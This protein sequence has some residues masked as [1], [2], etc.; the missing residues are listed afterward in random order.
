TSHIRAKTVAC[1]VSEFDGIPFVG[2]DSTDIATGAVRAELKL[3]GSA[4]VGNANQLA[5]TAIIRTVGAKYLSGSGDTRV[6]V[7][8]SVVLGVVN[9]M[10]VAHIGAA[11]ALQRTDA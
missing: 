10:V 9:R 5:S 4:I 2:F 11:S 8:T 7:K 6:D 1:I 3:S